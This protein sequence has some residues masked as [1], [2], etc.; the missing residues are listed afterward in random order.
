L[1][2]Q[3]FRDLIR[4]VAHLH[5]SA[6]AGG[7]VLARASHGGIAR[8]HKLRKLRVLPV[9]VEV[10]FGKTVDLPEAAEAQA[11]IAHHGGTDQLGDAENGVLRPYIV[12]EAA[13]RDYG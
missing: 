6:Q 7:A 10:Q 2:E 1:P 8:H 3:V 4:V 13:A 12:D 5:D 9:N 11:R